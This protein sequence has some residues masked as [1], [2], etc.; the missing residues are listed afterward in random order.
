MKKFMVPTSVTLL[1][2]ILFFIIIYII[3]YY[4][5]NK[6]SNTLHHCFIVLYTNLLIPTP[7]PSSTPSPSPSIFFSHHPF[8]FHPIHPFLTSHR[9]IHHHPHPS[10]PYLSHPS[11]L[12]HPPDVPPLAA[13][14]LVGTLYWLLPFGSSL[15]ARSF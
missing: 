15:L 2:F 13:R 7:S 11:I 5:H 14:G 3:F 1:L 10:S 9:A 4:T 6:Y 12:T 8:T